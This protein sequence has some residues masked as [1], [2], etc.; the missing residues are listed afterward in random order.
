MTLNQAEPLGPATRNS[1]LANYLLQPS[2]L[3]L[4]LLDALLPLGQQLPLVLLVLALLLLQLLPPQRLRAL[5]VGQLQPQEIP[6][7]R[8]LPGQVQDGAAQTSIRDPFPTALSLL[9]DFPAWS[10]CPSSQQHLSTRIVHLSHS[11]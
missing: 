11:F 2:P 7:Q 5:L 1:A 8:R 3:L 4:L 9:S 6:P 10:L